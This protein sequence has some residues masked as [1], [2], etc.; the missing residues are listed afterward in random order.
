[1]D[2][3]LEVVVLPVADV[4]RAKRF[5]EALGFRLDA[6]F[7]GEDGFRVVQLTPPGS[8]ASI[9]FGNG[10]SSAAPG[11]VQGLYLVV[12]RIPTA[13]ATPRSRHSST[14]TATAGCC[15]K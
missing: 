6:D 14:R 11:S 2:M 13:E 1:M 7:P 8:P 15:R 9:I 4:D 12:D 10:V 5:Y 3:K